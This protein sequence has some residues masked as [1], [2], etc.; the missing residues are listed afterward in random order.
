MSTHLQKTAQPPSEP[1]VSLDLKSEQPPELAVV[2][3]IPPHRFCLPPS[4]RCSRALSPFHLH[5]FTRLHLRLGEALTQLH[6]YKGRHALLLFFVR[7][8]RRSPR[9]TTEAD[10]IALVQLQL[11]F[12]NLPS[13]RLSHCLHFSRFKRPTLRLARLAPIPE[14]T[15]VSRVIEQIGHRFTQEVRGRGY[16]PWNSSLSAW[17]RKGQKARSRRDRASLLVASCR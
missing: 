5:S 9:A 10:S 3:R 4:A 15:T 14:P 12:I 8:H 2:R 16:L 7:W 6:D 1:P 17:A 13:A 11:A